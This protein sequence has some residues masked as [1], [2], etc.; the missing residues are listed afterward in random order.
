MSEHHSYHVCHAVDAVAPRTGLE[1]VVA[2]GKGM[3]GSPSDIVLIYNVNEKQWR[4]GCETL[5]K[6]ALRPL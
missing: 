6:V 4:N 5:K 3:D 1:V 2:G